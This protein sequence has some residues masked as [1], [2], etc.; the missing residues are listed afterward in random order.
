MQ[1]IAQ[2]SLLVNDYDEG[3]AFYTGKLNFKLIKDTIMSETKQRVVIAPSGP[4]G[5]KILLAKA[6][7]GSQKAQVGNQ[8]GGRVFLFLHTDNIERDYQNLL[9]KNVKILREP[10]VMSRIL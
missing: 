2:I 1:I 8:C 7:T 3:I 9:D 10:S 5:C 4:T 6:A